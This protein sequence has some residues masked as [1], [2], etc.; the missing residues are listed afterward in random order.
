MPTQAEI[1][2]SE[3]KEREENLKKEIRFY[4]AEETEFLQDKVFDIADEA[5]NYINYL[6]E[7]TEKKGVIK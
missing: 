7:Q 2:K 4:I 6:I 3:Y 5:F 1:E